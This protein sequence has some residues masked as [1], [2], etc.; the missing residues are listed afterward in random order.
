MFIIPFNPESEEEKL[1]I[2]L[3]GAVK[4][5]P[6]DISEVFVKNYLKS[7]GFYSSNNLEQMSSDVLQLPLLTYPFI[8]YILTAELE[9]RELTELGSGNSTIL[10]STLFKRVTSYETEEEWV[11]QASR[12]VGKNTNIIHI[13]RE[14]IENADFDIENIDCLLIDFAG[15]RTKFISSYL[16]KTQTAAPVIFLDNSDLYRIGVNL[17]HEAGYKEIP[18]YGLKSGQSWISCTSVFV[19]DIDRALVNRKFVSNS[20][21]KNGYKNSWDSIE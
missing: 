16:K 9:S 4:A 11:N 15:K 20:Y 5:N 18:F 14:S 1:R 17:L 21:T 12:K 8:D 13:T 2:R 7:Q 19:N 10:F 3:A 6:E